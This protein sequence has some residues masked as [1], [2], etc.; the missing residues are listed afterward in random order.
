MVFA[1]LQGS[2]HG[3]TAFGFE[4]DFGIVAGIGIFMRLWFGFEACLDVF[5][6]TAVSVLAG[7]EIVEVS[8][9]NSNAIM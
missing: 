5:A 7:D 9:H 1:L 3:I 2:N 4:F 6:S 8:F